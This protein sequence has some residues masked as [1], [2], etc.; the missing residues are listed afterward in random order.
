MNNNKKVLLSAL[1]LFSCVTAVITWVDPKPSSLVWQLRCWSSAIAFLSAAILIW[2]MRRADRAPD[3]LRQLGMP[4]FE[5]KGLCF[6]IVPEQIE[7]RLRLN[8]FFQNRHARPCHGH[9]VVRA[10][11]GF[12]L[13]R[14]DARSFVF[15]IECGGAEFGRVFAEI[16]VPLALQGQKQSFDVAARIDYPK[17]R[18]RMLR[19]R[20]GLVVGR[21]GGDAL[22]LGIALAAAATGSI[23]I[24]KPAQI[25]LVMPRGVRD[26]V[27]TESLIARESLWLPDGGSNERRD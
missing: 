25:K 5:M 19:F 13:N 20:D 1:F 18:G 24:S 26:V 17:G 14:P 23:H 12:W 21:A 6:S 27:D 16:G 22:R 10:S 7:D 15:S 9:V 4:A 2:A 3:F 11:K 8:V